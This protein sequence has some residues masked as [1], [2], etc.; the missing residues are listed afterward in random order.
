[1]VDSKGNYKFDLGVGGLSDLFGFFFFLIIYIFLISYLSV[2]KIS[3]DI[4]W[5]KED[6]SWI[7]QNQEKG[8]QGLMVIARLKRYLA[9]CQTLITP[10][11]YFRILA[12]G[13]QHC[14]LSSFFISCSIFPRDM[15]DLQPQ[16]S[17]ETFTT[18]INDFNCI[19]IK[20]ENI[21]KLGNTG[22]NSFQS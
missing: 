6:I 20:Q 11:T 22:A 14:K 12:I 17:L 10:C 16:T 21:Y 5:R 1:M 9:S 15:M 3:I 4:L 8:I 19:H 18:H 13:S 2:S 7:W